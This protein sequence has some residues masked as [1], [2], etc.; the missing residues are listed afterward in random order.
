MSELSP[1]QEVKYT[2]VKIRITQCTSPAPQC[3]YRDY[4]GQT[5]S[6]DRKTWYQDGVET[7]YYYEM[8]RPPGGGYN[9]HISPD[10][11]EEV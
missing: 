8:K 5:L 11:A 7:S 9:G 3:W 4:V 1:G 10:D 2:P 6:V